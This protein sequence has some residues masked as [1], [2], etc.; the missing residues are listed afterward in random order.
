MFVHRQVQQIIRIVE[1]NRI[2][3]CKFSIQSK[4]NRDYLNIY[5]CDRMF[6]LISRI[7]ENPLTYW[8]L[9]NMS[10][11][12]D[13]VILSIQLCLFFCLSLPPQ[14]NICGKMDQSMH[15]A[16]HCHELSSGR[17]QTCLAVTHTI[18]KWNCTHQTPMHS[19]NCLNLPQT[20]NFKQR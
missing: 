5:D 14:P 3:V 18:V 10:K 17:V 9:A 11:D 4:P 20:S 12:F 13:F 19:N 7:G 16:E 6:V 8:Q 2:P 15:T 1:S